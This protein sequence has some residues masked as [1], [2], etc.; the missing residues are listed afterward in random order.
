[1][2]Q[3]TSD[4]DSPITMCHPMVMMLRLPFHA[5]LTSTIGP[6]SRKRRTS[7]TGKSRF[8][9]DQCASVGNPDQGFVQP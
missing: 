2:K 4:G 5:E 6:G 9:M 1:M 7:S 8:R 3:P